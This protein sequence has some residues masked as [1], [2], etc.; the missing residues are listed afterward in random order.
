MA[1]SRALSFGQ[2]AKLYDDSRPSYPRAA[3]EW[4]VGSSAEQQGEP[5]RVLDLAAGTGKLTEV[6][7]RAGF[8]AVAVEPDVEMSA[9]IGAKLPHVRV[10]E[11]RDT[12]IPLPDANVC[13]VL[14]AQAWHWFDS[15]RAS[16]EI[17]RVL[18]PGGALGIV[19]NVYDE[20]VEWVKAYQRI[21]RQGDSRDASRGTPKV[22]FD[23][24][25]SHFTAAEERDFQW[26]WHRTPQQLVELAQSSSW[27]ISLP[28]LEREALSQQIFE[29]VSVQVHRETGLVA[30][31]Y[32]TQAYRFTRS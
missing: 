11:G 28:A 17:A 25:G 18:Q 22:E 19:W 30:L 32:V 27:F 23:Q 13:A 24:P 15:R 8:E 7:D 6:I 21:L 1:D 3:V 5:I 9:L 20:S 14:V 29:L 10:I 12:N 16:E 31:P 4:M 2:A 26:L